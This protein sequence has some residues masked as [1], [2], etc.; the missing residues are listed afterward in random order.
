MEYFKTLSCHQLLEV[1]EDNRKMTAFRICDD[2]F[3][4]DCIHASQIFS[5]SYDFHMT[6]T[7]GTS[8]ILLEVIYSVLVLYDCTGDVGT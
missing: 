5:G 2:P 3:S 4:Y 6:D 7:T 8:V 1:L